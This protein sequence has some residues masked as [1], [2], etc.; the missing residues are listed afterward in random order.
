M[1]FFLSKFLPML[2]FPLG[3]ACLFIAV[4]LVAQV[5]KRS[6]MAIAANLAALAVLCLTGNRAIAHLLL[7]PLETRDIPTGPLPQADAIVVLG[8]VTATAV[9]PQPTIHLNGGADRLTYGA[10]LYRAHKAPLVVLSGGDMPWNKG[11][12]PESAQMSEVM[13]MLGVPRSAILEESASRNCHENAV[14]TSRLLLAR[15]LH[16]ILLVTSAKT[17]PRAL[18]AFRHEGLDAMAAPTDFTTSLSEPSKDAASDLEVDALGLLPN[19]H[20][21]DESS[22]ALHEYMGLVLYRLAGWI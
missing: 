13:Q 22:A 10:E 21:I 16:R 8:A 17:M 6:R 18:A 11:L 1:T 12:P 3:T 4:S 5:R 9:P 20:T 19:P 14:Y 7:R 2:F 15:N